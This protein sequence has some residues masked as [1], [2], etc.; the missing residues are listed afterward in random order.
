MTLFLSTYINKI[1]K[2]GRVSVPASFRA[3]LGKSSFPEVVLFRSYKHPALEGCSIE[4]MEQLSQ[5][6]DS[7]EL[8]SDAQD[9]LAATLFADAHPLSFDGEGRILIPYFLLSYAQ[10]T[11]EVAFVGRGPT[12]QIWDPGHFKSHQKHAR[13]RIQKKQETIHLKT[14]QEIKK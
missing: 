2:K 11:Q 4:R 12:F 1:D 7:L 6:I 8:F 3:T 14:S 5:S 10:I 9:D 13:D